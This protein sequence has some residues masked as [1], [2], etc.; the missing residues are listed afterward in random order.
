MRCGVFVVVVVPLVLS[1]A[2]VSP[3]FL[4]FPLSLRLL[5]PGKGTVFMWLAQQFSFGCAVVPMLVVY[6]PCIC[7]HWFLR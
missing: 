4:S 5:L 2:L 7:E 6:V 1:A 3:V